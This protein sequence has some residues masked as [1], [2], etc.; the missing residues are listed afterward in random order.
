MTIFKSGD[1]VRVVAPPKGAKPSFVHK[2]VGLISTTTNS[3]E[4][5]AFPG[6]IGWNLKAIPPGKYISERCLRKIENPGDDDVDAH[7]I[8]VPKVKETEDA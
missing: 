2:L 5:P 6:T 8:L 1:L 3:T 4:N 7:D